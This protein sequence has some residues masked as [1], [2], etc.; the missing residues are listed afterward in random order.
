MRRSRPIV[1]FILC[2]LF[3]VFLAYGLPAVA[4][5][6]EPV[7]FKVSPQGAL[8]LAQAASPAPPPPPP[9]VRQEQPARPEPAPQPMPVPPRRPV[10]IAPAQAVSPAAGM[11]QMQFDNIELR[12]LIRFV[13]SIMG[14]NFVYDEAVVKGR[15][16]VLSPKSLTKEEV[17]RVFESVLNYYGFSIVETPEALKIVRSA[18]AK[19][20]AVETL[21]KEKFME[22]SPEEKISTLVYPLDYLDSN[23]MVGILRPLMSRD[24]YLVSVP[25]ANAI[26]MID[27]AAN[28]QRLKTLISEVDVPVSKQLSGI[29][30]YNVQHTSA[31]DLAKALQALLAEGKKTTQTPREKI[32]ITSYPATNSL[33]ISAPPEDMKEIRRI[34]EEI[35]TYRPQVLVEAAIVEL[36]L[37]KTQSLGVEWLTGGSVKGN[38]VFGG[39]LIGTD[40]T[41]GAALVPLMSGISQS[42][43][44]STTTTTTTTGVTQALGALKSGLN[45]GVIGQTITFDGVQFANVQA[46]VQ[47]LAVDQKANILSTPQLLTLNNEEAEVLVG[48]NIPYT[49]SVRLDSAGN[50]ITNFDYRDVG[51]H[52]KVKPYINKD[53]LVYLNIFAEVTTVS[54][55][56]AQVGSGVQTAPTTFK[57]STKTTVGVRDNQTIVISGIIQG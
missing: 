5:T 21:D 24:A 28:L 26:L 54:S 41:S 20:M 45:L 12:D 33:L 35:D 50:P 25:S 22:L 27:T 34:I 37:T 47:A 49:T 6:D 32:F 48:S 53:G 57:R 10:P 23:A 14:K 8:E 2:S 3:V 13:S 36:T 44:T 19:G 46:F 11:V 18:D 1:S 52:L 43:Q 15:V 29:E 51:V 17:F 9:A 30:I 42:L 7:A 16:T 55:T 4:R 38:Q 40:P 56:T 39:N 31:A